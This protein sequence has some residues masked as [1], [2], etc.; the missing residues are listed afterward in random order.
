MVGEKFEIEWSKLH[1]GFCELTRPV[2]G[3]RQKHD[4][5]RI[6]LIELHSQGVSGFGELPALEIPSYSSEWIGGCSLLLSEV[7][8]P[9]LMRQPT[10]DFHSLDW[11]VGHGACRFALE[12]ALADLAAKLNGIGLTE[13]L[14]VLFSS[15][16]YQ[17]SRRLYF[18]ASI[19][20]VRDWR[21]TL[22]E[23]K[24]LLNQGL[25]RVKFK[26][27]SNWRT[28]VDF[29]SLPR[30]LS[31]II[32]DFNGSLS[33]IQAESL[34]EVPE[35]IFIEEPSSDLD[36]D[37]I[38]SL[39]QRLKRTLIL[40]ESS[41]RVYGRSGITEFGS[42]IAIAFKPFRVGSL[43][44]IDAYLTSLADS[45]I[46]AYLGGM[47]ESDIGRRM[48]MTLGSHR[49]FT[50]IGDMGPSKWYCAESFAGSVDRK[51]NGDFLVPDF[52]FG[53]GVTELTHHKCDRQCSTIR[54]E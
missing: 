8:L 47:F 30:E 28:T 17:P 41:Q 38:S 49:G 37:E 9:A 45:K 26:V 46:P 32:L 51:G 15:Q 4:R 54:H 5:R 6:V 53:I 40:D 34:V 18:G 50:M 3:S 13:Y 31:E 39:A 10:V 27:D 29:A 48:L 20:A 11:L 35:H 36:I 23:V 21:S 1:F 22:S 43:A 14:G 7:L 33:R 44:L 52:G 2:T 19:S 12:S 24:D 42:G 25:K 16:N